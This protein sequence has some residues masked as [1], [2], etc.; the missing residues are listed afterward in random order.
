MRN[1]QQAVFKRLMASS[2]AKKQWRATYLH[3]ALLN[4]SD[5]PEY[6]DFKGLKT[7]LEDEMRQDIVIG[8]CGMSHKKASHFT[9]AEIKAL[10]PEFVAD[11]REETPLGP[12]LTWQPAMTSFQSY[13]PRTKDARAKHNA[14]KRYLN[15]SKSYTV[16]EGEEDSAS[17]SQLKALT[18]CVKHLWKCHSALGLRSRA[19]NFRRAQCFALDFFLVTWPLGR[20]QVLLSNLLVLSNRDHTSERAWHFRPTNK[21]GPVSLPFRKRLRHGAQ[22]D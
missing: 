8:R 5:D 13:Y 18:H 10:R 22:Q 14:T 7:K 4:M 11:M 6:D 1:Y 2:S 20:T 16:G 12:V 3:Q 15:T 19:S 21:A 17:A 9:P